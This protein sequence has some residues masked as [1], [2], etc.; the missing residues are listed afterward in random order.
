[1]IIIYVLMWK[2][3][4]LN[5]MFLILGGFVCDNCGQMGFY[6][7]G[8]RQAYIFLMRLRDISIKDFFLCKSL[9]L[10]H[11][12]WPMGME[13]RMKGRAILSPGLRVPILRIPGLD[14]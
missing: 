5:C 14:S 7:A 10:S 8:V 3:L 12:K 13:L 2:E 4:L 9:L 11:M 6:C 1:M